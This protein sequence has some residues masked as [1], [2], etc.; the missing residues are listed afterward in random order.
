MAL[1]GSCVVRATGQNNLIFS[2]AA[3]QDIAGNRSR[4][5]WK[6]TLEAGQYGKITSNGQL[7]WEVTIAGQVTSGTASLAIGNNES[8]VLAS[9]E[10]WLDHDSQGARSFTFSFRQEFGMELGGTY[11]TVVSGS[12]S[13]QLD[14]ITKASQPEV[15]TSAY[16]GQAIP[17]TINRF[18]P[19]YTHTL[20]YSFGSVSGVIAQGV[21]SAVQWMPPLELAWQIPN[22]ASSVA[23]IT[24]TT[25][26]GGKSMGSRQATILLQVPDS[27]RPTAQA[28]WED[29]S[30][31]Y[32]SVGTLVQNISKLS[33]SVHGTGA[34]G[35]TITGASVR[36][37]GKAYGGGYLMDS[38]ELSLE[39]SVTD[40]RG[41]VGSKAYPITVAP[42]AVPTVKL[43][44]SRYNT[45]GNAD[46]NGILAKIQV[47]GFTTQVGERNEA[48]LTL[49]Y[50]NETDVVALP[51]GSYVYERMLEADPDE[52]MAISATVSDRL[53]SASQAMTLSTGYATLDLL[54]GGK[55]I[56]FGKAATRV[57]FECA[58]KA[59]FGG[60][61]YEVH[62]DGSVDSRSLF[63]R[64]AA[65]EQKL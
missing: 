15:P 50:G 48:T 63:D 32:A 20:E 41:R 54:A 16:L 59:Y 8:K 9:G 13:A 22:A 21:G 35:S 28:D 30:G 58:M 46:D 43:T 18:S 39:V 19:S 53:T 61:L 6:M 27:V 23:T 62:A 14:A 25:M 3:A 17:I 64:V 38:G 42:Y 10:V 1:S 11:I 36:L 24:C 56:S 37:N 65:L 29:L 34:Y 40:S 12:D 55:G 49:H 45:S 60:G 52:T 44:A 4:I 26:S 7:P 51:L 2:W 33:V 5:T 47:S 31:A 57:G